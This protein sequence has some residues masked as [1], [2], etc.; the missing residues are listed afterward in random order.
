MVLGSVVVFVACYAAAVSWAARRGR[1]A[2]LGAAAVMLLLVVAGALLLGHRHAV[3]SVPRLLLYALAF[4][5]PAVLL[6]PLLLWRRTVTA[7]PTL[8]LALVST[9]GGLLA[10]WVLV[11]F[12]LRV[13]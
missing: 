13:W 5:G 11:V 1:G 2:L 6:P 3:P 10:G 8:P 12:G 7:G 4:L 9:V